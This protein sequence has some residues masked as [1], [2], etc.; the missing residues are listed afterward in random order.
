[1]EI[2]LNRFSL[3]DLNHCSHF[4]KQRTLAISWQHHTYILN[5]HKTI[6]RL[7]KLSEIS[8][9]SHDYIC[10][11]KWILHSPLCKIIVGLDCWYKP[12]CGWIRFPGFS[13]VFYEKISSFLYLSLFSKYFIVWSTTVFSLEL[14]LIHKRQPYQSIIYRRW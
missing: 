4:L 6:R 10:N 1:M 9:C 7:I 5:I 14:T 2:F 8:C 3:F 13:P 12:P 11:L